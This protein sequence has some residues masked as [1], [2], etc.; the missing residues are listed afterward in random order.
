M[1]PL[2]PQI[3]T[4]EVIVLYVDE[5]HLVAGD[6]CGYV[7]GPS[8]QRIR[9]PMINERERQTYYGAIDAYS[10]ALVVMPLGVGNTAWTCLFIEYLREQYAGKRI[11]LCW[12][13][14]SYHRSAAF[15]EYLEAV[16]HGYPRDQWP[17]TCLQFAP[18][19][20][21]QNPIEAVW[22]QAKTYVRKRWYRC[23]AP[24]QTII[25]LFEEALNTLVLDFKKLRMYLPFLQFN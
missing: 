15:R 16:N 8:N 21:D 24:F 11:I 18:H 1:T 14:A 17:L 5:C 22:L 25:D 12:D 13:G 10:G 9:V 23:K 19:A 7:W 20:P 4:Q 3:V 2:A 6:A